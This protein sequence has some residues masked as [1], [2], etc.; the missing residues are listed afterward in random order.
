VVEVGVLT[1]V[2]VVVVGWPVEL[3]SVVGVVDGSVDVDVDVVDVVDV[4]TVGPV[5]VVV[6][7]AEVGKG[8]PG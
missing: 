2:V 3:D 5:V 7:G 4:E 6:A 1:N 8:A